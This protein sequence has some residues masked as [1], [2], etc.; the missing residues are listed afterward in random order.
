MMVSLQQVSTTKMS[1]VMS[2]PSILAE[3]MLFFSLVVTRLSS[4][5]TQL[6]TT[7]K[8]KFFFLLLLRKMTLFV[9]VTSLVFRHSSLSWSG[10]E[11]WNSFFHFFQKWLFLFQWRHSSFVTRHSE[12]STWKMKFLFFTF[13]KNDSFTSNDVIRLSSL[14]TQMET[15]WKKKSF[16]KIFCRNVFFISIDVIR[17]SSLATQME[18]TWKRK[19]FFYFFAEMSFLLPKHNGPEK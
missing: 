19:F 8:M 7:W 14:V 9:P 4:L 16:L 12:E 11:K 6:E 18:L 5:V 15:T 3:T 17:L 1:L 2:L 13:C 10:H